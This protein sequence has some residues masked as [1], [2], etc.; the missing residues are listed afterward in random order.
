MRANSGYHTAK[1]FSENYPL[2]D[3]APSKMV[4]SAVLGWRSLKNVI[5][6]GRQIINLAEEPTSPGRY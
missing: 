6:K 4:A 5:L 2:F 1:T 3:H